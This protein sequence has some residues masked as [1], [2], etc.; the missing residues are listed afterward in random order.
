MD[1]SISGPPYV[2]TDEEYKEIN[3][4]AFAELYK[5][6][7]DNTYSVFINHDLK[8]LGR[9]P[10]H[11][12]NYQAAIRAGFQFVE[13]KIMQRSES[14]SLFRKN[15]A[16]IQIF[17]KGDPHYPKVIPTEFRN[18]TWLIPHNMKVADYDQAFSQEFA[19]RVISV[20]SKEGDI[21][22]DPFVGSG[23]VLRAAEKLG[24]NGV[25]IDIDDTLKR[26][27]EPAWTVIKI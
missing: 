13:H 6:M 11:I 12:I 9:P 23:T 14:T 1:L 8:K 17:K 16:H 27:C 19:E 4:A 18:D 22:F 2:E 20:L 25:G 21:V 5:K 26:F 7:K 24:R 15:F 10:R 3:T